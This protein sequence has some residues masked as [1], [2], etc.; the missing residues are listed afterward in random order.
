MK[1]KMNGLLYDIESTYIHGNKKFIY[2]DKKEPIRKDSQKICFITCVNDEQKYEITLNHINS[3]E[4]PKNFTVEKLCLDD[5][6]FI[7]EAYNRAIKMTDAKYKVYIHQDVYII[8][9][10]FI[11]D[12]IEIFKANRKIGM[13]GVVGAKTIPTSGKYSQSKS[14]FGN[15]IHVLLPDGK[16]SHLKFGEFQKGYETVKC[17]DGLMMIS[18][19]DVPWREDIFTGWH[20]YDLSQSLEFIKQ[21]YEVIVPKMDKIWCIHDSPKDNVDRYDENYERF[22]KIFVDEYSKYL[23]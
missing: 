6:Q 21:G 3:L 7:T 1:L 18:Q 8:N 23:G 17:I 15:L 14:K 22:R 12:V 9:P 11:R 5:A 4:I 16:R 20:F 19:Y 2:T 10:N 13:I